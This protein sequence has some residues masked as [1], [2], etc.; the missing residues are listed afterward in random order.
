MDEQIRASGTQPVQ[1]VRVRKGGW[2]KAKREL[3]LKTVAETC[4]VARA[5]HAAG[6]GK[7]TPY[8]LRRADP[9]FDALWREALLLGYDRLEE[10]LLSRAL[11]GVNAIDVI[12]LVH[13]EAG[14]DGGAD[15]YGSERGDDE[16]AP[17]F[18]LNEGHAMPPAIRVAM[19]LLKQ[20]D[21]VTGAKPR[22]GPQRRPATA[23]ETDAAIDRK[24]D[25]LERRLKRVAP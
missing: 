7:S 13:D 5:A 22:P 21:G 11:E 25:M 24:L 15:R 14:A 9:A 1:K 10:A 8:R 12:G 3:F 16:V 2:T 23:E 19:W 17:R 6:V 20:H 4:N 18:T